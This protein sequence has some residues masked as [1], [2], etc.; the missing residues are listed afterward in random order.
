MMQRIM[1]LKGGEGPACFEVT[2]VKEADIRTHPSIRE[3]KFITLADAD[4]AELSRHKQE[5]TVSGYYAMV[6][7]NDKGAKEAIIEALGDKYCVEVVYF[8]T[9]QIYALEDLEERV[10]LLHY[11]CLE[12]NGAWYIDSMPTHIIVE[13]RDGTLGYYLINPYREIKESDL[14]SYAGIHPRKVKGQPLPAFMYR[15]YGLEKSEETASEVLHTRVTPSE[16]VKI[17]AYAASQSPQ[18]NVSDVIRRFIR[19]IE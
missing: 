18:M 8:N 17:E 12:V 13:L 4:I 3:G 2:E 9:I 6:T 5:V 1:G 14:L 7:G 16:K 19:E 15:L 10:R 11:K